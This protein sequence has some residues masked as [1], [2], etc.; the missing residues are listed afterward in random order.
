MTTRKEFEAKPEWWATLTRRDSLIFILEGQGKLRGRFYEY[1][2]D[3]ISH[4]SMPIETEIHGTTIRRQL[5]DGHI[6]LLK[7]K[8]PK[9][10]EI[11]KSDARTRN[12]VR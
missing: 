4:P 5:E 7:G 1:P 2:Q 8:I 9:A 11:K 3:W 6:K 10:F 12:G